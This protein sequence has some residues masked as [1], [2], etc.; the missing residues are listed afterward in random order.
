MMVTGGSDSKVKI[1]SDNTQEE[2]LK[3]K[4]DKLGNIADEQHLSKLLRENNLTQAALLAFK[5][6][7]IRD[8]FHVANRIINGQLVPPRAFIPGLMLP[9]VASVV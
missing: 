6:K 5:L 1:W 3:I 8:F 7:K 9:G 2:E 4:Q